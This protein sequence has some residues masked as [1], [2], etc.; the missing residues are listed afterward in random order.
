[1]RI[2]HS[3]TLLDAYQQYPYKDKKHPLY[4]SKK[5]YL[6]ICKKANQYIIDELIYNHQS[7]RLPERLGIIYIQKLKIPQH[8]QD[9][10]IDYKNTKKYGK[11]IYHNNNHSSN[12]FVKFKWDKASIKLSNK[13][14]YTFKST[15][16]NNRDLAKHIKQSSS[17]MD[18][19]ERLT[20]QN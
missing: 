15:R 19:L 12:Y 2:K 1:M 16:T 14:L 11:P 9:R 3:K 18:Y 8:L 5:D 13:N 17:I 20:R 7:F 6:D 10:A 4:V